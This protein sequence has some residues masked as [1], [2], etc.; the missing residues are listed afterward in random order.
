MLEMGK[1]PKRIKNNYRVIKIKI[2]KIFLPPL[3]F[4]FF[5]FIGLIIL[6]KSKKILISKKI[7]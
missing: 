6:N 7:K 4:K 3:F 2:I 1:N 5:I